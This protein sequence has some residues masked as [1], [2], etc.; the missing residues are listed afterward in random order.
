[1]VSVSIH[2]IWLSWLL[3]IFLGHLRMSFPQDT[4]VFF[5]PILLSQNPYLLYGLMSLELLTLWTYL[6]YARVHVPISQ[7]KILSTGRFPGSSQA[8][9]RSGS[10]KENLSHKPVHSLLLCLVVLWLFSVVY[11]PKISTMTLPV[12]SVM[13][14]LFWISVEKLIV[15][16]FTNLCI[17]RVFT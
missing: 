3:V 17:P 4:Q 1:M 8:H 10:K 7:I 5:F 15:F 2:R 13:L 9:P 16:S 14:P 12:H 6:R 11:S